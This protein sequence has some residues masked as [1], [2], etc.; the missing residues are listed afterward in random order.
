M[1]LSPPRN[2]QAIVAGVR[3][4]AAYERED[5]ARLHMASRPG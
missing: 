5:R 2:N 4:D 1:C 3:R